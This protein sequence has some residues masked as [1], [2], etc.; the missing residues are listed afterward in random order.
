MVSFA[1]AF[2]VKVCAFKPLAPP[3]SNA[4]QLLQHKYSAFISRDQRKEMRELVQK[5]IAHLNSPDIVVDERHAPKL[6]AKF[7]QGLIDTP[8]AKLDPTSPYIQQAAPLPRARGLSSG[9][10]RMSPDVERLPDAY[11]S[12]HPST[13]GFAPGGNVTMDSSMN[14][15][16]QAATRL[17]QP[18]DSPQNQSTPETFEPPLPFDNEILQSM[19]SYTDPSVWQDF[20]A[21]P[22]ESGSLELRLRLISLSFLGLSWMSHFQ[23]NVGMGNMNDSL[24][25]DTM[26]PNNLTMSPSNSSTAMKY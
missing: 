16:G 23:S 2:L 11:Y 7:L 24:I 19:Q 25:F 15:F 18:G 10:N 21:L 26:Q 1:S 5:V 13:H 3:I 20:T 14:S 6:Y 12:S 9:G 4:S 22:G 8:M 17:P